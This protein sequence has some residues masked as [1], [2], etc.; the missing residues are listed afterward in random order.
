MATA[1]TR[2]S[3]VAIETS[4]GPPVSCQRATGRPV[5]A[6]NPWRWTRYTKA[7]TSLPVYVSSYRRTRLTG[8]A[9][10]VARWWPDQAGSNSAVTLI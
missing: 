7:N 5:F 9:S 4:R 2:R 6:I 8:G 3:P 1:R 10:F